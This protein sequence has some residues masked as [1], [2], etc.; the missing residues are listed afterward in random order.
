MFRAEAALFL[1]GSLAVGACAAAPPTG[2]AVLALPPEGKNFAQFQQEEIT[3]RGHAEQQIGYGSAQQA[4]NQNA[5]GTAAVGTAVGAAAGAAIGAAAGAAGTG[6]AV[7]AGTGLLAGSAVGTSNASASASVLQQRYD[8]AYA[9]CMAASGNQVQP[10]PTASQ[11]APYRYPYP[12]PDYYRPWFGP[13]VGF[14][15]FGRFGPRFHHH[16]FFHHHHA[17]F[18]HHHAFFHPGFHRR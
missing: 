14:G 11:Y 6:A 16:A 2:P 10:L 12:Y 5:I 9:Q 7:G 1:V 18:H 8:I 3:C 13:S 17:F 15:F 4:A